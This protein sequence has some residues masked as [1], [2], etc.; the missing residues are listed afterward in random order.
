MKEL[1]YRLEV[2]LCRAIEKVIAITI[3]IAIVIAIVI[4]I[5]I[6]NRNTE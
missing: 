1:S 6:E 2:M 4:V 3:V 5:A